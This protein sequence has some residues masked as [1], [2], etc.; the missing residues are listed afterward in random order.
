MDKNIYKLAN[1]IQ[2]GSQKARNAEGKE[3][4]AEDIFGGEKLDDRLKEYYQRS[5]LDAIH[6]DR[7]MTKKTP[8]D[9]G[10]M[11]GSADSGNDAFPQRS[12][13]GNRAHQL[14]PEY[15]SWTGQ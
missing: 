12:A 3:S 1:Q 10:G 6:K 13:G 15:G 11:P 9:S 8:A 2:A 14:Q 4:S 7:R 5:V